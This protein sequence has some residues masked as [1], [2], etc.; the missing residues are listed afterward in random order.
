M[1]QIIGIKKLPE[2]KP[3][4][5]TNHL[6]NIPF[7]VQFALNIKALSIIPLLLKGTD[8]AEWLRKAEDNVY[9]KLKSK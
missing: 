6:K 1:K 3:S 4:N 9:K 2:N 7:G 5:K 8:S